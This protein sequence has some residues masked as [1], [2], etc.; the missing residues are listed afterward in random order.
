MPTNRTLHSITSSR[1]ESWRASIWTRKAAGSMTAESWVK[2][3]SASGINS[4]LPTKVGPLHLFR[5]AALRA[6]LTDR[7]SAVAAGQTDARS[8]QKNMQQLPLFLVSQT[9]P[10]LMTSWS[11]KPQPFISTRA[12][13]SSLMAR[14]RLPNW[15]LSRFYSAKRT[16]C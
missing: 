6:P 13:A 16:T 7:F 11:K 14:S 5:V 4:L 12:I 10:L 9:I 15:I 3:W 2:G 8:R 1:K